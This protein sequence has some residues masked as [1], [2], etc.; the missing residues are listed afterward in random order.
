MRILVTGGAGFIGSHVAE[1]FLEAGHEVMIVDDLS[2]GHRENIP[3]EAGFFECD[4]REP[5]LINVFNT[6]RPQI[7]SHHAAQMSVRVSLQEPR[8]DASVNVEGTI[9][10]LECARKTN[11]LKV[12]YASTGGALYGEP[13]Y[14]PCDERHPVHPLS[15]YGISKHTVEHY[16]EL[17]SA[18]YGLDFTVLR[19]PNV[20]GPRQD[21]DGEAGVV[22]I[23]AGQMLDDQTVQ[24]YGDGHQQR[25]FVHVYDVA[26]ANVLALS[27]GS[28]SIL[29]LGSNRGTS[30]L[31]IFSN[32]AQIIGYTREPQFRPTRLGEVYRIYLTGDQA[33]KILSW[34]PKISLGEGLRGTVNSMTTAELTIPERQYGIAAPGA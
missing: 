34:E 28:A 10:L 12:I 20:Y 25:D 1:H 33:R 7:V 19:Y 30:V 2:T 18:L 21:R 4:I 3:A 27:S 17:Y 8:L 24:V 23:F 6:F 14:V 11:V 5:R 22:A 31:E 26:R 9:N 29:N 15:H 16:L 13:L 32:L